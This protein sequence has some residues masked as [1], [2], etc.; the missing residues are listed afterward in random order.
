MAQLESHRNRV[1]RDVD[2]AISYPNRFGEYEP[3]L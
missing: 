2:H 3:E 1:H